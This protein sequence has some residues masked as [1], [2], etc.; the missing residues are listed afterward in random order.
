MTCLTTEKGHTQKG[1]L[2]IKAD[3]MIELKKNQRILKK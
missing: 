2:A 3:A 1:L